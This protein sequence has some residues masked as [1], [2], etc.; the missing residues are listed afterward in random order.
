MTWRAA[1]AYI[2]STTDQ[3]QFNAATLV[4]RGVWVVYRLLGH[5]WWA[6][7]VHVRLTLCLCVV[8]RLC[9]LLCSFFFPLLATTLV[10]CCGL[11]SPRHKSST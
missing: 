11:F 2:A 10:V 8:V 7:F 4:R 9:H 6:P 1:Q 5:V 3:Y